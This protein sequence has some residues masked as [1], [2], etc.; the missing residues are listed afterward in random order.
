[1]PI[2]YSKTFVLNFTKSAK[3]HINNG[4]F[5][6]FDCFGSNGGEIR[7]SRVFST[8]MNILSK[9]NIVCT[10]LSN[11]CIVRYKKT[12]H[13]T[14]IYISTNSCVDTY[15]FF[16]KG[17]SQDVSTIETS[18]IPEDATLIE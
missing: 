14:E 18:E 6:L 13:A 8:G 12:T 11:A 15:F 7:A 10:A 17:S 1:M 3:I 16:T 4:D 5:L 2:P 9:I